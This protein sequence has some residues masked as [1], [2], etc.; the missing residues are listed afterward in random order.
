[1][2]AI[3]FLPSVEPISPDNPFAGDELGREETAKSLT[4][5]LDT[6]V[7]RPFTLGLNGTWGS[8][9]TYFIERWMAKL[10]KE[11]YQ[12]LY[13][14]AWEND[15]ADDPFVALLG[16]FR[17]LVADTTEEL[18]RWEKV[19]TASLPILKRVVSGVLKSLTMRL[20]T[21][22][23]QELENVIANAVQD[24][25]EHALRSCEQTRDSIHHFRVELTEFVGKHASEPPTKPIYYFI[26]ELDRCRPTF[27]VN[28]L[29]RVKHLL[30]VPGIVFVFA[31]DRTQL[32]STIRSVYG[33]ETN[34]GGY[35]LRF[36]DLEYDLPRR[37]NSGL[38]NQLMTQYNLHP[39]VCREGRVPELEDL[40]KWL[41]LFT[42][43]LGL[44]IR[45]IHKCLTLLA[46]YFRSLP[47][48]RVAFMDLTCFLVVLRVKHP[49]IY[50]V[51]RDVSP[52][53]E[54]VVTKE[55]PQLLG[56]DVWKTTDC[57]EVEG[58]LI[59]HYD[60]A[61]GKAPR[62]YNPHEVVAH[63]WSL[64]GQHVLTDRDQGLNNVYQYCVNKKKQ[65]SPVCMVVD[66][67]DF[68]TGF[69]TGV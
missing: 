66:G 8:G 49:Q 9:K 43:A 50:R 30:Q 52:D 24:T 5:F 7:D 29:E 38:I 13:F 63:S 69:S 44:S 20:I 11:G 58:Y 18:S 47:P 57:G 32:S 35:L 59:F 6:F 51:I 48:K 19:R 31:W 26:D 36:V 67:L 15:F 61:K 22:E 16:E 1:M 12:T 62:D 54:R 21:L 4:G 53:Y 42:E 25:A 55:L 40:K 34:V 46:I 10:K 3:A 17:R 64:R 2:S 28:V 41:R 56:Q 60:K 27:A 39:F 23:N 68:A 45:E 37:T 14:N 65:I 33:D